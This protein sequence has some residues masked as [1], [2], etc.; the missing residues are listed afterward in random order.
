MRPAVIPKLS[1]LPSE[2]ERRNGILDSAHAEPGPEHKPTSKKAQKAETYAATA[3]AVLGLLLSDH[4]NVTIGGAAPIDE[5]LVFEDAPK[6]KDGAKKKQQAGDG[7]GEGDKD[8]G[9]KDAGD[10]D[11]GDA[12]SKPSEAPPTRDEPLVPWVRLK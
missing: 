8:A 3:A 9:D 7:E 10:K 6:R 4:K 5:N 11:A 1:E 2:P 12:D